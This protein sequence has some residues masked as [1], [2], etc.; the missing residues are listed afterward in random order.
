VQVNNIRNYVIVYLLTTRGV[1]LIKLM[2]CWNIVVFGGL[3]VDEK[4][5]LFEAIWP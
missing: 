5:G 3:T 4:F 2:M 1:R